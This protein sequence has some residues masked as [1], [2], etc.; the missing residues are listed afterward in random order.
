MSVLSIKVNYP[1]NLAKKGIKIT[2]ADQESLTEAV[3]K[4]I[5]KNR[6]SFNLGEFVLDAI[7][8]DLP[9]PNVIDEDFDPLFSRMVSDIRQFVDDNPHAFEFAAT[10]DIVRM[11]CDEGYLVPL[12]QTG[13]GIYYACKAGDS[14]HDYFQFN[15]AT[16]ARLKELV[17]NG[18]L[19]LD[20]ATFSIRK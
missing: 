13:L 20:A 1:D 4:Y 11:V 3:V 6:E 7:N 14:R 9:E 5:K 10:G 2:Y 16:M 17:A 15:S 8:A 19:R 12:S 18:T